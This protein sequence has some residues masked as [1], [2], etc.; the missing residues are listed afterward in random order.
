MHGRVAVGSGRGWVREASVRADL[1]TKAF[2]IKE[3]NMMIVV[4]TASRVVTASMSRGTRDVTMPA[5]EG[6]LSGD[7]WADV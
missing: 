4:T 6:K 3:P 2:S 1:I 5:L 7:V